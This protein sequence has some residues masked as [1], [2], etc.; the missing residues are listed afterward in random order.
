MPDAMSPDAPHPD[1]IT[2]VILAGGRSRR[3]G[4]MDK[5]LLS[6]AGRPLIAHVADILRP[7]V[8]AVWINSNRPAVD[9]AALG[10]PVIADTL[11]NQPGPLAGLI[12][13][14]QACTTPWVLVVPCDTPC[15][16]TDL[17]A[18][19]C[20]TV[21]RRPAALCSISDGART[22]AAV[23]LAHRSMAEPLTTF[24]AD[25]GRKVQDWLVA[26]HCI[27][28]D[29]S[30]RPEAFANANTPDELNQLE[31]RLTTHGC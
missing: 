12:A 31:R 18:R 30:D 13:A 4:G 26:Q 17:V 15:L 6:L 14:F 20:A 10:L 24:L 19:M 2:A 9:Y 5:A 16:P 25:G 22:H 21:A 29:F 7:Q 23:I 3:M 8:P 27:L 11:P 1:H 28:A